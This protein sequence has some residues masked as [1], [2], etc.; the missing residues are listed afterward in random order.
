M[1]EAAAAADAVDRMLY[2]DTQVRLP[3]HPVM[4]LDRMTMAHG[5]EARA[6]FMDHKIAEF[7]ARLPGRMKVRGRC[8]R[9]I[10]RRLA[11]KYLPRPVLERPKQGFQSAL[12]YMLNN[13]YRLVFSLF[14]GDAQLARD[15]I[16]RQ[17]TIDRLL[18]EHL[19]GKADHGNRLW[20]LV[21]SELW[22]RMHIQGVGVA[23]LA[24]LIEDSAGRTKVA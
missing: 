1:C 18:E 5:L 6:P 3:D 2:A 22:Y 9:L 20:L 24:S 21:N 13:E 14:L 8:T 23:D 17:Q 7:A 15:G 12:P 11:E 19:Y 16:F 4:I 10:Q